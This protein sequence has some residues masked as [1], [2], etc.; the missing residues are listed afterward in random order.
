MS[1]NKNVQDA[2]SDGV[3]TQDE[4]M[5]MIE[6]PQIREAKLS[7]SEKAKALKAK[8][9]EIDAVDAATDKQLE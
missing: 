7:L 8:K 4:L 9:R 6:T 3:L 1:S 2:L 5:A